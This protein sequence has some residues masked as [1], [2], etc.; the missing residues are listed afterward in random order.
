MTKPVRFDV[1]SDIQGDMA[2]LDVALAAFA[3]FTV[4]DQLLINGDL[5]D[6]GRVRQYRDLTKHL[7]ATSHPPTLF[8]IG[9]HD[10]Y[11]HRSTAVSIDRFLTHTGMSSLYS[12]HDVGGVPIIRLGTTDGSEKSGHYVI[13]GEEQLTWF[14]T[15]LGRH[16]ATDPVIVLS[17][18]V[19][20]HTVSGSFD[21]P[22]TQAPKMYGRD[23]AEVDRVLE[24]LGAHQNVL[25]LSG[26]SHWNLYRPD[27]FTRPSFA[28]ANTGAIQR[29][30]GP[31]GVGGEQPLDGPHN[32]GLRI[33]VEG[34]KVTVH[35]LDFVNRR[36]AHTAEFSVRD[37]A[38]TMTDDVAWS[39]ALS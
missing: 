38:I 32:Q 22:A 3:E 36:V 14:A 4:A 6:N 39:D 9:N 24:I 18:H 26:H 23:Y 19:L 12:A 25:F 1:I 30:F 13:L 35:A 10:F 2:D 28:A 37:P 15:E 29:G 21:D 27:W 34:S 7:A 20:F 17:H 33:V 16:P 8:T 11:N 5:T 31:D